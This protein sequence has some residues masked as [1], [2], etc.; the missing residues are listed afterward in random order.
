LID[1]FN[2]HHADKKLFN[3]M[4]PLVLTAIQSSADELRFDGTQI[5]S[6]FMSTVQ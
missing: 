4:P 6:K 1:D 3:T 2:L 5:E